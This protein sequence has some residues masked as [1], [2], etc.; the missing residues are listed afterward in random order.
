MLVDET[1]GSSAATVKPV[2]TPTDT[3]F[4]EQA[5]GTSPQWEL[6]TQLADLSADVYNQ[7]GNPPEPWQRVE[8]QDLEALGI[9][10]QSRD[11][12]DIALNDTES[13]FQAAVYT[14]GEGR[15]VLA[16]AG[17]DPTAVEDWINNGQQSLGFNSEQYDRAIALSQQLVQQVGSENVVMTGHS[18]G[19]GLASAGSLATGSP[20][21]TFNAAGI[22]PETLA[23]VGLSLP[24]ARDA[25]S[26]GL[27]RRY[28]VENDV[29]TNAQQRPLVLPTGQVVNL[30][31]ALGYEIT[32]EN[33]NGFED[34]VRAH[35]NGAVSQAMRAQDIKTEQN[36]NFF[37]RLFEQNLFPTGPSVTDLAQT[38]EA[39]AQWT[40]D[41]VVV[42]V[43][44]A[45][46]T[47]AV[48]TYNN[49]KQFVTDTID[50]GQ[51]VVDDLQER[52][53][54]VI[55]GVIETGGDVVEKLD[56]RNWSWP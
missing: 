26:D 42:P 31:D 33:P 11:G 55:D 54:E 14:D 4:A 34:P 39:A 13:G 17:T 16:F 21:V 37:E 19:G 36:D 32:L 49:G 20:A 45:G 48:D 40:F 41:N 8:G 28:N 25:A 29:L 15:Y 23:Q 44:V 6:D 18:L 27:I 38:G 30:P 10:Q 1:G 53:G 35:L 46:V 7:P 51:Q 24:A 22:G 52:G 12:A 56:P 9:Q 43:T 50:A 2:A 3:G 5:Y 47:F